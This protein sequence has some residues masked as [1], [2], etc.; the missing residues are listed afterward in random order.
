MNRLTVIIPCK[1]EEVHIRACIESIRDLADEVLVADSGSTDRTLQIVREMGDC[2]I[3]EREYINSANF[4]NWAIPQAS[5]PWVLLIDADE[6]ATEELREEVREI[7]AGEPE[8]DGYSMRFQPFFMGRPLMHSCSKSTRATRLFRRECRYDTSHVHANID[9]PAEKVKRLE[10]KFDHHTSKSLTHFL[11]KQNRYATWKAEDMYLAG[12]RT[13]YLGVLF[14]PITRFL[15]FYVLRVGFLDG[16]PGLVM[17]L[18][19][20]YY[21]F[22]KYAKLWEMA[23]VDTP[24]GQDEAASQEEIRAAA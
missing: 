11:A 8:F 15:Q 18:I 17:C 16:V 24:E 12:R 5:H 21:T 1:D 14:R 20:A 3:I 7:L 19:V 4:K 6:R 9:L 2:R 10:G 13:G 23:N 22:M